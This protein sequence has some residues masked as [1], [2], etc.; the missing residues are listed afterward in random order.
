[1]ELLDYSKWNKVIY[2]SQYAV[3]SITLI[4]VI[5]SLLILGIGNSWVQCSNVV[6]KVKKNMGFIS[7]E[8][9]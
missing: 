6:L 4:E 7:I 8:G 2:L 5:I 3:E 1:M 9:I